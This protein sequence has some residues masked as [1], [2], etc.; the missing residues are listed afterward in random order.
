MSAPF[1]PAST[2]V[3]IPEQLRRLWRKLKALDGVS[4]LPKD[5][6]LAE[7]TAKVNELT[8]VLKEITRG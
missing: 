7:T 2:G 8:E 5:A 3:E 6:T 4:K 1:H